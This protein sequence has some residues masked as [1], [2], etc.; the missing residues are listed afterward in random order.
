MI[1]TQYPIDGKPGKAYKVTSPFGWRVHPTSGQKSHHN[2][3]DLWGGAPTIYIES[4]RMGKV[5][6]AGPSKSRKAD[7]S[8]GGFGFHVM[9]KHII[10]GEV[11]I[12][13]YAH[14]VEGSIKVKVGDRVLAGT[15]LGKMGATGDVTGKH[16]HFEIYKGKK[17]TWSATG[18]NFVD[19]MAFIK[20]QIAKEAV[21]AT[22][23]HDTP[24]TDKPSIAPAHSIEKPVEK[25]VAKVAAPVKV[26]E[27]VKVAKT[28]TIVAGDSYWSIGEKYG[29]EHTAIQKANGH[30]AL[31]PGDTVIIP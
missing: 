28:H 30:K 13:V 9:V 22:A 3:V 19:P 7:G 8:L 23:K 17:Y 26:K 5:V 11:Y 24:H 18:K 31:H 2:G 14:M 10:D 25:P 29:I 15:V 12:S 21:A 4:F 1:L 16:L 27:P 6:F 20:A